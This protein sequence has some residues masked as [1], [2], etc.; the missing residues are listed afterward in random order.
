MINNLVN[1]YDIDPHIAEIYD[2][3]ETYNFITPYNFLGQEM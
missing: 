1:G 3:S 2:Q